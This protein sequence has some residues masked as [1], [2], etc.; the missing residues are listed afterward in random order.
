MKTQLLSLLFALFIFNVRQSHAQLANCNPPV[1]RTMM[2][3][4]N[5]RAHYLVGGPHWTQANGNPGFEVPKASGRTSFNAMN[6]WMG[7]IDAMGLLKVAGQTYRQSSS[8]GI[9]FW[10]GPIMPDSAIISQGQCNLFD[11]SWKLTAA[12]IRHHRNN[13]QL[14]NYQVP[15]NIAEWPGNGEVALGYSPDLAPFEDVNGNGLYDPENGDYPLIPGDEAIWMVYND[16]YNSNGHQSS[17]LGIEVQE[18]IFAFNRQGALRNAVFHQYKIINRS[19]VR[20]DSTFIGNFVE[21]ALGNPN[22]DFIGCDVTHGMGI[23]YNA[24]DDDEGPL[25]YGINPRQRHSRYFAVPI[26]RLTMASTIT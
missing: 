16:R 23:V 4:N 18:T 7:G 1:S 20:L 9:G 25:G 21:P 10:P 17:A 3:L 24:D 8:L 12:E 14:P 6:F 19:T 13:Y 2:E 15:A 5:I 26:P 22:D 11:R